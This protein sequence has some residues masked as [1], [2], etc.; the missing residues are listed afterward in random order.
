MRVL[1]S[2]P[3]PPLWAYVV[4]IAG[5]IVVIERGIEPFSTIETW[6][7]AFLLVTLGWGWHRGAF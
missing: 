6:L 5:G 2:I 4:A 3:D 1:P 7:I